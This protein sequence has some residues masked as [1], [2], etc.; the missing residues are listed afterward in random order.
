MVLTIHLYHFTHRFQFSA[1][2][3]TVAATQLLWQQC[4]GSSKAAVATMG[5]RQCSC[6]GQDGSVAAVAATVL[7]CWQCAAVATSNGND[8]AAVVAT[9]C[10]GDNIAAAVATM[11]R[12]CAA[13]AQPKVRW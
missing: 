6:C 3:A 9:R 11:Q 7:I 5:R 8:A 13:A 4:N 10:C 2:V 12:L 1:V